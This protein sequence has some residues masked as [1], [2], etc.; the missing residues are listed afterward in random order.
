M[1]GCSLSKPVLAVRSPARWFV[2]ALLAAAS[3]CEALAAA[4]NFG[5]TRSSAVGPPPKYT[6]SAARSNSDE[7]VVATRLHMPARDGGTN[8]SHTAA[9]QYFFNFNPTTLRL[10]DGTWALILRTVANQTR[11][12]TRSNPDFLTLSPVRRLG[13]VE[14]HGAIVIDPVNKSSIILRSTEGSTM[15]DCGVQDPR[16]IRDPVTGY[17]WLTA[18]SIGSSYVVSISLSHECV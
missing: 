1:R 16:V 13:D 6:V 9:S 11:P 18:S 15:D 7:P 14:G 3:A 2:L 17:Y 12:A 8:S 10:P 5:R 4:T